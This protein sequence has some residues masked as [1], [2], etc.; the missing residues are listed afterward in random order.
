[1]KIA[2]LW[3]QLGVLLVLLGIGVAN[4]SAPPLVSAKVLKIIDGDTLV[5]RLVGHKERLRLIG[6]DCPESTVNEKTR[7]DSAKTGADI[8]QITAM[9][10][11]AT[12][13]VRSL[14]GA[15]D[16]VGL[17]FDAQQRDKYGRLLAYVYLPDGRMLNE[18]IAQEGYAHL[19]TYP[20]NVRY[21]ER[22][23]VAVQEAL[24]H[25]RGL[26]GNR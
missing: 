18:V 26:W 20:P 3:L 10:R 21:T 24:E 16:F 7:Q 11:Q 12:K 17:E 23:R 15:G 2:R 14:V 5:V 25:K 13:F 22:F 1:M 6:I 9:G 8:R 19:L 4:A